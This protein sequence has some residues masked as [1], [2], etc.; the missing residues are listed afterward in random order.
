MIETR[1]YQYEFWF[2]QGRLTQEMLN[3]RVLT[4]QAAPEF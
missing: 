1:V 3:C 4:I 2:P